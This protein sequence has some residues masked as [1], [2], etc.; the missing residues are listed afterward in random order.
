MNFTSQNWSKHAAKEHQNDGTSYIEKRLTNINIE[1]RTNTVYATTVSAQRTL[2]LS[3]VPT[4]YLPYRLEDPFE[5]VE[6]DRLTNPINIINEEDNSAA[7]EE[8]IERVV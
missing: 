3:K 1:H 6:G 4:Q 8:I 5:S 2:A 7:E